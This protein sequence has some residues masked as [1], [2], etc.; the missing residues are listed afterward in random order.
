MISTCNACSPRAGRHQL[1][2]ASVWA[3]PLAVRLEHGGIQVVVNLFQHRHQP[4][5][6][7]LPLLLATI[8]LSS[9]SPR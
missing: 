9:V 5:L 2:E 3:T 4:A 7:N 6:M 8:G 1:A